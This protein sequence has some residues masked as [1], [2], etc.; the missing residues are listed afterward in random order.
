MRL[1]KICGEPIEGGTRRTSLHWGECFRTYERIEG[2]KRAS[3]F[4][5]ERRHAHI[6]TQSAIFHGRLV[7]QPCEMC[8]RK[9]FNAARRQVVAHHD[10]YSKPL[11]IRWLCLSCH[12]QHHLRHG[13]GRFAYVT[14]SS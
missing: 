10:D 5:P 11:D 9:P 4:T 2:Q 12:R 7:P 14:T 8:G 6:V 1:C 13:S 3:R